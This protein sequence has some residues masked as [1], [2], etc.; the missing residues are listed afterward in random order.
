M[1]SENR[2]LAKN[3]LYLYLRMAVG[4]VVSLYTS[5]LVL[6]QLGIDGYG[7]YTVVGSVV[8]SLGFLSNSL[9]GAVSRFFAYELGRGEISKMRTIFNAAIRIET[10]VGLILLIILLTGGEW[11]IRKF[12][13]IP[14]AD[15]YAARI[16]LITTSISFFFSIALVPYKSAVIARER[17]GTF[18]IVELA[19]VFL[20]LLAVIL[21]RFFVSD[22]LIVYAILISFI[23][24]MG[25]FAY[26][27]YSRFKF[28]ECRLQ[29]NIQF[30]DCRPI[31][32]YAGIDLFGH[33]CG[34]ISPQSVQ[35]ISNFFFGIVIN[36]ALGITNQVTGAVTSFVSAVS[37]AFRPRI[38]KEYSAGNI[39]K[40]EELIIS[41]SKFIILL[42]GCLI[43]P[44]SVNLDFV[45]HLWLKEVPEGT[46]ILCFVALYGCI[47]F[48]LVT[49][50]N[51]AVHATGKIKWLSIGNGVLFLFVPIFS[52]LFFIL[53]FNPV[54]IFIIA[55]IAYSLQWL[56]SLNLAR[57][58]VKDFRMSRIIVACIIPLLCLII[59]F[60]LCYI[61]FITFADR[62]ISLILTICLSIVIC[63][64]Y[65]L[66]I[67]NNFK[68]IE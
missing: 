52:Y 34:L 23:I 58:Y 14:T 4:M 51:A 55:L 45:L 28:P 47:P 8:V 36:A 26:T 56:N 43:V 68:R 16:V 1:E 39:R 44:L 19:I 38:I 66:K 60:L 20:K 62:W 12:L 40:V 9:S 46:S 32:S 54:V 15:I 27:I 6:E 59:N 3:S 48:S 67:F 41:S 42:M 35:W 65:A 37:Q 7:V 5:R 22:K 17:F 25:D 2:S 24:I 63:G 57:I 30:S 11:F 64:L 49:I 18:A 50:G 53:G 29:S 61:L 13:T 10:V 33:F 21:L 31:I